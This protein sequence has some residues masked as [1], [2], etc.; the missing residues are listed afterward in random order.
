LFRVL[1]CLVWLLLL[2][3]VGPYTHSHQ[4]HGNNCSHPHYPV[5]D[6]CSHCTPP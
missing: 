3:R 1:L 4:R 5:Q 6:G 2:L